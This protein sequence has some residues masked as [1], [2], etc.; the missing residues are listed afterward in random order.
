[1]SDEI[2]ALLTMCRKWMPPMWAKKVE[3]QAA[4]LAAAEAERDEALKWKDAAQLHEAE[5]HARAEAAETR[6]REAE[7]A[8]RGLYGMHTVHGQAR[9]RCEWCSIVERALSS[10]PGAAI[11]QGDR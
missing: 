4:A 11:R 9:C 7:E 2:E 5:E 1:M 3:A 10:S 8:L 6:A